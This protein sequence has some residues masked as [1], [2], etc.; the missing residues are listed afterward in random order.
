[1]RTSLCRPVAPT[2]M[3]VAVTC[4]HAHPQ[5]CRCGACIYTCPR[6]TMADLASPLG[7]PAVCDFPTG[8]VPNRLALPLGCNVRVDADAAVLEANDCRSWQWEESV[9]CG[10][11]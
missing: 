9:A 11:R 3:L 10:S 6:E 2:L 5:P 4:G 7:N 1:M 8:H